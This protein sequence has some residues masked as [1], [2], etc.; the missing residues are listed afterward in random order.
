MNN[1]Q[2]IEVTFGSIEHE[3]FDTNFRTQY[4]TMVLP[5]IPFTIME[6]IATADEEGYPPTLMLELDGW[7][8]EQ[9]A[10]AYKKATGRELI[11]S[12]YGSDYT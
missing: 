4:G 7:I 2:E 5:P 9:I 3:E 8:G 12:I 11:V 1:E 6:R 10:V